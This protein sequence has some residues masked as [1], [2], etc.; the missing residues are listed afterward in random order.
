[1]KQRLIDEIKIL[2]HIEDNLQDTA[3]AIII[4]NVASHLEAELGGAIPEKLEFIVLEISI[5]RY[6]RLGS[7]GMSSESVE[8][9]TM[10]FNDVQ[11]ELVPYKSI[12]DQYKED[13]G[14]KGKAVF[15]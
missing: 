2:L 12:I 13:R 1:M 14:R 3:I 6:N 15:I 10:Q 8:G 4:K 11:D 5:R 7:E 9:H